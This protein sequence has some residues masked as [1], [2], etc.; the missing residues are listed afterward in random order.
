MSVSQINPYRLEKYLSSPK[1]TSL[2]NNVSFGSSSLVP[3]GNREI[4]GMLKFLKNNKFDNINFKSFE[5]I[6]GCAQ[7]VFDKGNIKPDLLV[8]MMTRF[9]LGVEDLNRNGEPFSEACRTVARRLYKKFGVNQKKDDTF[10]ERWEYLAKMATKVHE[11][12][13][14]RITPYIYPTKKPIAFTYTDIRDMFEFLRLNWKNG[15]AAY[16]NIM[17]GRGLKG[18]L[19][20]MSEEFFPTYYDE[21]YGKH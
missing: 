21:F 1:N 17:H 19:S 16:R 9:V 8:E 2:R 14:D 3:I 11:P 10:K 18:W 6:S 15:D 13:F 12:A 5:H 7:D 20:Y 4:L